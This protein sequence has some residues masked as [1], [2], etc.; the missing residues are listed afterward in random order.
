VLSPYFIFN[1]VVVAGRKGQCD[2]KLTIY[3]ELGLSL[4]SLFE[5]RYAFCFE[6]GRKGGKE[7]K[8]PGIRNSEAR[9]FCFPRWEK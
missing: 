7:I 5:I 9:F 6:G 4:P 2:S 1:S 8:K 3:L